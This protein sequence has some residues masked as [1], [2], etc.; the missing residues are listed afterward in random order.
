VPRIPGQKSQVFDL[1]INELLE[2]NK[3][4]N[5]TSITDP[6][7]IRVKHFEDSLAL[8]QAVKLSNQSLIDVGSGAGFP[9]IPLKIACPTIKLTLL[10]AT[11][12]KID[13]LKHLV[14]VLELNNVEI[15]C[16]RAEDFARQ[17][18][19]E[20]DL[21]VSRAVADLNLLSEYCLPFVKVDGL[22]IAY[23][24]ER[25]EE[26]ASRAENTIKLLGGELKEIKKIRLSDGVSHSLVIIEKVSLT[27]PKFPRR[28]GMAK[29]NPL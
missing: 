23:K 20:F 8:L 2:W 5:L 27:P 22:F 18:R 21:A 10:E 24:G 26:E 14:A 25:I 19:E 28:P 7:E 17:K 11:R 4:F 9:G 1:Y 6:E 16:K 12:K 15:I 3:K 29:K 13:F